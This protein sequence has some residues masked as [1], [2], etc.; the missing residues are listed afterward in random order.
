[1]RFNERV[2]RQPLRPGDRAPTKSHPN[3]F[4]VGTRLL[5]DC[6][7]PLHRRSPLRGRSSD[8]RKGSPWGQGSYGITNKPPRRSPLRG[9]SIEAGKVRPEDRAPTESRTN[10]PVGAHSVGEAQMPK[11]FALRTGLLR[12]QE[13]RFTVG[14]HSVG[15][16]AMAD[17]FALRT[18]LLRGVAAG[19]AGSGCLASV[20]T[21]SI[22]RATMPACSRQ[23]FHNH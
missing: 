4:A 1:M 17:R 21:G 5:R 15:E 11:S 9:R 20:S 2:L 23:P 14:A 8:A 16:A 10:R 19:L 12:I 3:L 18:G 22:G 13:G 7:G 6:G